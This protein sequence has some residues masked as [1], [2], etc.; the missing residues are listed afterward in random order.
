MNLELSH[1]LGECFDNMQMLIV[2]VKQIIVYYMYLDIM[3]RVFT[4][5]SLKLLRWVYSCC[6]YPTGVY[7]YT[8]DM[9]PLLGSIIYIE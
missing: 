8:P 7:G 5:M 6:V 3:H 4:I 9:L 1:D 2:Y